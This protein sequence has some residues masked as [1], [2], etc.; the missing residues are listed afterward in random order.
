M[1][2]TINCSVAL[3]KQIPTTLSKTLSA[4][5]K[6]QALQFIYPFP[7]TACPFAKIRNNLLQAAF[8]HTLCQACK[9][10]IILACCPN[11]KSALTQHLLHSG[12]KLLCISCSTVTTCSL[13]E[14][15]KNPEGTANEHSLMKK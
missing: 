4:K 12:N 11:R 9:S 3:R 8:S 14:N 7:S 1:T 6:H 15:T 5:E 2:H 13:I 10:N